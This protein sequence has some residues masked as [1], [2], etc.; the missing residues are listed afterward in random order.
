MK[1]KSYLTWGFVLKVIAAV[2]A[3]LAGVFGLGSC[4]NH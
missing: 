2:A 4:I 1:E 3:A